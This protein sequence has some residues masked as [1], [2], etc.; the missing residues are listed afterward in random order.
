[1][2]SSRPAE[3]ETVEVATELE[4][5]R[6]ALRQ[7][8]YEAQA[9]FD[10][11]VFARAEADLASGTFR[12]VNDTFCLLTGYSREEL[13]GMPVH[14]LTHPEDKAEDWAKFSR[15][16]V[17]DAPEYS[18]EKR[19]VRKDGK[20]IWVQ[21]AAHAVRD[22]DGEPHHTIG[23]I[24]DI[25]ARKEAEAERERVV[26]ALAARVASQDKFM[27]MLAHELRNP[28][29]PIRNSC[30]ILDRAERSSDAARRAREVIERQVAHLSHLIDELLDV[31]RIVTG[32][33]QLHLVASE[34]TE[35]VER[36][37]A[38]HQACFAA[39]GIELSLVAR[40]NR[41]WINVDVVRIVQV[42]GNLLS[43]AAK[44]T[45]RGG[46]TVV[47]V[48]ADPSR[49]EA[50]VVVSDNGSGIAAEALPTLF[51]P[52]TQAA[53][54]LDRSTGGLGLGLAVV[55]GIVEMHGGTVG[56]SSEGLGRGTELTIR[57]PMLAAARAS[58]A[59]GVIAHA[60]PTGITRVLVIEDNIDAADTLRMSLELCHH[61][62]EV[63]ND[64]PTGLSKAQ[65]FKPDVVVCD[66][67][68]PGMSGYD[69]ARS[70]RADSVLANVPLVALTGYASASDKAAARDAGFD[71]HVTKPVSI[72]DLEHILARVVR[73]RV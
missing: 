17:G 60:A 61:E 66:I 37:V 73:Q 28:L 39:V 48:D 49:D 55:K 16:L 21:V 36:T 50:L 22:E 18:A 27:A 10:S 12:R 5:L 45:Q 57:L 20:V 32:K 62:V 19:Y 65:D 35:L 70:M 42:L 11:T 24:S 51:D 52:F 72:R 3:A 44:F 26:E 13:L 41:C 8:E 63:A 54:T 64:G 9:L 33:I 2:T 29:S 4:T 56:A 40:V 69:V 7:S 67:G 68:L 59:R 30:F 1:M 14:T 38:D 23:I 53:T 34:L 58:D 31:T 71:G 46:A 43:N 47:T 15:M 25:T 6:H